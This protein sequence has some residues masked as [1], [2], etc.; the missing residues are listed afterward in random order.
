MAKADGELIV[1]GTGDYVRFFSD[2][3][4]KVYSRDHRWDVLESGRHNALG[5]FVRLG[6]GSELPSAG[7][8]QKGETPNFVVSIDPALGIAAAATIAADNGTF[9]VFYHDGSL[10]VGSDGRDIEETH[11]GVREGVEGGSAARGASV[12]ISFVGTYRPAT[13][14]TADYLVTVPEDKPRRPNRLYPGEKEI[15]EGKLWPN[16]SG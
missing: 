13:I 10:T 1:N 4:V 16:R 3:R 6:V 8:K 9:V 14:R 12:L 5:E 7:T 2:G 15:L 11:N